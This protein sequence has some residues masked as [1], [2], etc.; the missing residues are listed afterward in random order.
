MNITVEKPTQEKLKKLNVQTWPTLEKEACK[1][2]WYFD[3]T[4]ESYF[5][6]GQVTVVTEDGQAVE[7]KKGD[8]AI[9][10]K[11]LRCTWYIKEPMRKH[12]NLRND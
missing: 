9:F 3:R 2:E 8:L 12:F 11:G 5:L 6:E 4:E 7:V 10:P 1:I